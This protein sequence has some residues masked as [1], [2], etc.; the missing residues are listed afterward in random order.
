M[1]FYTTIEAETIRSTAQK[2]IEAY[3]AAE[4]RYNAECERLENNAYTAEYKQEQTA[5]AAETLRKEWAEAAKIAAG[6]DGII[7]NLRKLSER[8]KP[9]AITEAEK[10]ALQMLQ[11]MPEVTQA[12]FDAAAAEWT[13]N[14]ITGEILQSIAAKNGIYFAATPRTAGLTAADVAKIADSIETAASMYTDS[15]Q[16]VIQD[17]GGGA[18]GADAFI[19]RAQ[20][21]ESLFQMQKLA[22]GASPF[23]FGGDSAKEFAFSDLCNECEV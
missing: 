12:A 14:P 22:N 4:T 23:E 2:I 15:R 18:V 13:G 21:A 1:K 20:R 11:L 8:V 19:T 6:F 16:D 10:N 9:P 5:K 7:A 3:T 17:F